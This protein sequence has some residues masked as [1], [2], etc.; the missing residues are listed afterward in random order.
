MVAQVAV[1]VVEG[2][3]GEGPALRGAQPAQDLVHP[4][5]IVAERADAAERGVEEGR[6]DLE[7]PVRREV[8]RHPGPHV[9]QGKDCA[10][11]PRPTREARVEAG[12]PEHGEAGTDDPLLHHALP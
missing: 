12:G 1:A 8:P 5:E 9:V 10:L 11:P 3:R 4:D 2:E 6:L 7:Q